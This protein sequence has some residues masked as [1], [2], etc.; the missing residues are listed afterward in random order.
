MKFKALW[1]KIGQ[2]TDG[3]I[4]NSVGVSVVH[5]GAGFKNKLMGVMVY[6]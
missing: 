1:E 6:F 4:A 3:A 5:N 2:F